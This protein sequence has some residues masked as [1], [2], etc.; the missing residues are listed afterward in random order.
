MC[1][2]DGS[3]NMEAEVMLKEKHKRGTISCREYYCYKLQIR[4]DENIVLHAGRLFQQYMEFW[5]FYVRGREASH[6]GKQRYF[7]LALWRSKRYA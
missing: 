7:H 5:M 1:S 2:I 3:L 6:I 4:D